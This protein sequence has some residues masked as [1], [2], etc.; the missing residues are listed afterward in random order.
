[1]KVD[2]LEVVL[3]NSDEN[4]NKSLGTRFTT[5]NVTRT[6]K[7]QLIHVQPKILSDTAGGVVRV[8]RSILRQVVRVC[9]CM[10][11]SMCIFA[12]Q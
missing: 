9:I 4:Y 10:W 5:M 3:A 12:L 6:R 8:N 1:M 7:I 11:S 2:Y